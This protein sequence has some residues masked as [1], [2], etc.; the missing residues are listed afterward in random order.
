[1]SVRLTGAVVS[2]DAVVSI[3]RGA[4][5]QV[6]GARLDRPSRIARVL[7][8]RRDAVEWR[9][10]SEAISFDVDVAVAFGAPLPETARQVRQRVAEAVGGMTG[11]VV[12][13]VEVTVTGIDRAEAEEARR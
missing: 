12:R 3:V 9:V 1:V 2:D 7:P 10:E 5:G 11:L 4:V 8:G 13:S 6:E